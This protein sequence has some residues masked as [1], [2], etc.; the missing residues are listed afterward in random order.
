MPRLII[1]A[2][3]IIP[4]LESARSLIQSS[5]VIIAADGGSRHVLALGLWPS[6]IIGDLDS[7]TPDERRRL[8]TQPVEIQQHS[9]DKDETDLELALHF[10]CTS[11]YRKILVVGA[12]GGRLDQTLGNLSLLTNPEFAMLDICMDD[13]EEEAFISRDRCEVHG[14]PGDI[15]SL[16]PWSGEVHGIC[17]EG[18]HWP[19]RDETLYPDK[20]RG[21]S[22]EME[23]ETAAISQ[24]S[25]L[26]LV[27][28]LRQGKSSH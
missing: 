6:I 16:I 15:V 4:E 22:N 28:H 10:A 21:I 14:K 23:H 7:L 5:D 8:E 2:N 1:F 19:L 27:I 3:G 12:L 13:G 17:T 9:R 25:G 18:L 24:K 26:L 11:G 20:T